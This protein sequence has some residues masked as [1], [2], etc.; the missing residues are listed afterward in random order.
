[1]RKVLD[2]AYAL[3]RQITE[4]QLMFEHVVQRFKVIAVESPQVVLPPP[5]TAIN[6]DTDSLSV[7]S[8]K[9]VAESLITT[10]NNQTHDSMDVLVTLA[11]Q[12]T[13]RETL[14]EAHAFTRHMADARSMCVRVVQRIK[15][16][17]IESSK[18]STLP[19][20]A[21]IDNQL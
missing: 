6:S 7:T 19:P 13:M 1:M 8:R 12:Q 10:A 14:D 11:A 2:E 3:S 9:S 15:V 5:M 16:V 20:M 17:A 21:T 4:A 18:V